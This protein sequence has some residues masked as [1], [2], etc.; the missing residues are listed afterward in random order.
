MKVQ[1][2]VFEGVPEAAVAQETEPKVA[3]LCPWAT[4]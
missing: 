3:P 2:P 1:T 4:R